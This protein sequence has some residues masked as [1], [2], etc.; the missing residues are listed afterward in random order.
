VIV[1]QVETFSKCGQSEMNSQTSK[2]SK[3]RNCR[4]PISRSLRKR[5]EQRLKKSPAQITDEFLQRWQ[6]L[7]NPTHKDVLGSLIVAQAIRAE[8]GQC[9]FNA[10]RAILDLPD[11]F[12]ARYIE[13]LA[14]REGYSD[15][16]E[17]GWIVLGD[18]I[19][20]PTILDDIVD[21]F[22]GLEFIGKKGIAD[23]LR[24]AGKQFRERPFFRAF[25]DD[26]CLSPSFN[27]ATMRALGF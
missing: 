7:S 12:K 23:F 26:G 3:P 25:G 10:R 15:P 16:F 20:D 14:V 17:H 18:T 6:P 8:V 2:S 11:L 4:Q 13:G 19:I 9:Y 21:Y 27:D 22:P 5:S 24:I 1:G